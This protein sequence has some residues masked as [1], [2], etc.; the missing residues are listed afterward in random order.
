[1]S[2]IIVAVGIGPI[3]AL[4]YFR[5]TYRSSAINLL[6]QAERSRVPVFS[7]GNLESQLKSVDK[8]IASLSI[9]QQKNR[10]PVY[11]PLLSDSP[12]ATRRPV[13]QS[14]FDSFQTVQSRL[15][16]SYQRNYKNN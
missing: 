10:N 14:A 13:G 7:V 2:Q 4:K 3:L 9:S 15:S 8:D 11:E 1:M 16:S 5:Y 6:Q 12:T